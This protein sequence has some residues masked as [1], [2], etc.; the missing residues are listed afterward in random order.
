MKILYLPVLFSL[1][2]GTAAAGPPQSTPAAQVTSTPVMAAPIR[3]FQRYL[4]A[5]DGHRCPMTPSCSSYALQAMQR[6][7]SV[8]G[9]IMACDRLMRC[10]RDELKQ[11]PPVMTRDGLRW[12]DP[13]E[14]N[15][16]WLP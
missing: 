4:S 12:P 9:W 10:G 13:V 11:R 8:R 3:F 5:A 16:L 1:L 7:G 6:H 2:V 15:N 14:N